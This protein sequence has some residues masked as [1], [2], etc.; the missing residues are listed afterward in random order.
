LL[1]LY[2]LLEVWQFRVKNIKIKKLQKC[3]ADILLSF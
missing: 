3:L 1:A 2:G